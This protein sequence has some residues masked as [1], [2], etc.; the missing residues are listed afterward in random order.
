MKMDFDESLLDVA[1]AKKKPSAS[2]MKRVDRRVRETVFEKLDEETWRMSAIPGLDGGHYEYYDVNLKDDLCSCQGHSKGQYRSFC[3]HK[4]ALQIYLESGRETTLVGAR[5]IIFGEEVNGEKVQA[6]AISEQNQDDHQEEGEQGQ[7]I[8]EVAILDPKIRYPSLEFPSWLKEFRDFQ[9]EK[10]DEIVDLFDQG[11]RVV[12]LDGPTGAG[13][14][15][16]AWGV[17]ASMAKVR[18]REFHSY[19]LSSTKFLQQQF[20]DLFGELGA[21]KIFGR[22]NFVP[23]IPNDIYG[24]PVTCEDCNKSGGECDYCPEVM[25][26]PYN[27]AKKAAATA[28]VAVANY[29][30]AFN[31]WRTFSEF[32]DADLVVCDE[33]DA[34]ENELLNL[35]TI[36]LTWRVRQGYKITQPRVLGS[37]ESQIQFIEHEVLP[38][39]L[40]GREKVNRG[41]V[42]GQRERQMLARRISEFKKLAEDLETSLHEEEAIHKWVLTG[43]EPGRGSNIRQGSLTWKPIVV[44]QFAD[45][46]LWNNGKRFLVMSASLISS[47]VEAEATGYTGNYGT[48][49]APM[50][51]PVENRRIYGIPVAQVT[52]K[53]E[54]D[55]LPKIRH[56]LQRVCA[57]FPG[58]RILVHSVSYKWRDNLIGTLRATGR[59]VYTYNAS[60]EKDSV[61]ETFKRTPCAILIGPSFTRGIDFKG[62]EAEVNIIFKAPWPSLGDKRIQARA[63][64]TGPGGRRWYASQ[65]IREI[66]QMTGRTTRDMDDK[67]VTII[68]DAS[69]ISLMQDYSSFWPQWFKDAYSYHAP[70]QINYLDR[71]NFNI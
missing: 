40:A 52:L 2:R 71:I 19:Y 68:L 5:P 30:Y 45:D 27:V 66:I 8:S 34:L 25:F 70:S 7:E 29:A 12:Y 38:K 10:I 44:T 13:K 65:A 21:R 47:D 1:P 16:I 69:V 59:P 64:S 67:S 51:F 35:K 56:A 20:L 57:R 41:G 3:T 26:C 14:T 28:P 31:E 58:K 17:H 39:L 36:E 4:Q 48:V 46:L 55:A 23:T 22:R 50:P 18:D 53:N 37:T 24:E 32:R 9:P 49:V 33:G 42:K 54:A 6:E 43:Y 63:Y 15:L 62:S 11:N 61:V 60:E